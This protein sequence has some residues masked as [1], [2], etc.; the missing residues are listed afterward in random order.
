MCRLVAARLGTAAYHSQGADAEVEAQTQARC[1][2]E[3]RCRNDRIFSQLEEKSLNFKIILESRFKT[4][5]SA[6]TYRLDSA[7]TSRLTSCYAWLGV[8]EV[9]VLSTQSKT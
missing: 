8:S 9:L 2:M 3:E 7:S 5:D 1:A 4:I 6:S